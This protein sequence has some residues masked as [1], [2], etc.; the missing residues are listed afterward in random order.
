MSISTFSP[1]KVRS[2]LRRPNLMDLMK[3]RRLHEKHYKFPLPVRENL[4]EEAVVHRDEEV[5]GYGMMKLLAEV[6]M[7]LDQDQSK[8]E[9]AKSFKALMEGAILSCKARGIQ[10]LHVFSPTP[11]F[12]EVLKKRYGFKPVEGQVLVLN[13]L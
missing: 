13:V 3:V 1:E 5:L 4:I 10:Q 2:S 8:K 9:L 11:E 12:A 6:I 7:I